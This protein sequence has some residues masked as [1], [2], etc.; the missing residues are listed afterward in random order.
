MPLLALW[1]PRLS[2]VAYDGDFAIHNI[3]SQ[4]SPPKTDME[5]NVVIKDYSQMD[6]LLREERLILAK[7]V[8]LSKFMSFNWL[9]AGTGQI[10]V[11][12]NRQI[13]RSKQ[14]V[15]QLR[16]K[17]K[18]MKYVAVYRVVVEVTFEDNLRLL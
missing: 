10:E 15:H 6:R 11:L 3:V 14:R 18:Y 4:R 5:S 12:G 8:T 7:M 13:F 9:M 16:I 17:R 1:R 2:M